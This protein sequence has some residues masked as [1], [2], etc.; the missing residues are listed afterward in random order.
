MDS[1]RSNYWQCKR[2]H[3]KRQLRD[4]ADL[5]AQNYFI[6]LTGVGVGFMVMER[7]WYGHGERRRYGSLALACHFRSFIRITSGG[8][9]YSYLIVINFRALFSVMVRLCYKFV[10]V[11]VQS[12]TTRG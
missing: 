9:G 5:D 7:E 4:T 10:P 1:R 12:E 2:L 6:A 8:I 11:F 3:L